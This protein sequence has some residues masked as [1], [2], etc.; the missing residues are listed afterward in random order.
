MQ[1]CVIC[2]WRENCAKKF[3]VTDLGARCPD[4]S[5]DISIKAVDDSAADCEKGG[6]S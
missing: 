6:N 4:F 2:A 5:R 3:C 1:S